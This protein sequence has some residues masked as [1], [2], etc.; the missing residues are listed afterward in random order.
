[1]LSKHAL[2]CLRNPASNTP[3]RCRTLKHSPYFI[4]D[5]TFIGR[6]LNAF[7]TADGTGNAL[8]LDELYF[9]FFELGRRQVLR[10]LRMAARELELSE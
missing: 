5:P 7:E 10:R 4:F 6:L 8:N 9:K 3:S 1:M 2:T